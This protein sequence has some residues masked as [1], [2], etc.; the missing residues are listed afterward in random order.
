MLNNSAIKLRALEPDDL[1]FLFSIENQ[2]EYWHLSDTLQ[3]FSKHFLQQYLEHAHLD[4]Y[5]AKQLR[6]VIADPKDCPIGL[7]DLYDFNP[8]HK[9]AGLGIIL[10]QNYQGKGYGKT[11][12][13]LMLNYAF[14]TLDLHQVY[15]T[16]NS[17]NINSIK[18]FELLGFQLIGEQK[19]W[20]YSKGHYYSQY[21]YQKIN[22]VH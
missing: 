3:P 13:N 1:D 12:I 9:R 22:H 11:A 19:D 16:I 5:E 8:K 17:E 2:T 20:N 21:F 7:I 15:V 6:L 18:L 10:D 14:D 4:I